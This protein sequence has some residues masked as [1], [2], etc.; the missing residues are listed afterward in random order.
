MELRMN[1]YLKEEINEK[2]EKIN[3]LTKVIEGSR[4]L[5]SKEFDEIQEYMN[6]KKEENK[7]TQLKNEYYIKTT[8]ILASPEFKL[9]TKLTKEETFFILQHF[10]HKKSLD[11]CK[12]YLKKK[13]KL[14]EQDAISIVRRLKNMYESISKKIK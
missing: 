14:K 6:S 7:Y 5:S 10:I 12:A 11:E 8:Q 2:N 3:K 1:K 9:N 13:L 4:D